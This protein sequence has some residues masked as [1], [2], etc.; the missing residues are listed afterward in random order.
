VPWK[1]LKLFKEM[2]L[3]RSL[4]TYKIALACEM[5]ITFFDR[6]VLEL[7][8]YDRHTRTESASKP[9][10]KLTKSIEILFKSIK[11]MDVKL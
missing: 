1:N 2:L 5:Q 6:D 7:I 4:E 10:R 8:S 11:N 3:L 9:S